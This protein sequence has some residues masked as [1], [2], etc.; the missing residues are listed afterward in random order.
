MN[1]SPRL[2]AF[3]TCLAGA[4]LYLYFATL[5]GTAAVIVLA[6]AGWLAMQAVFPRDR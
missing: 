4:G 6:L 5:H 3:A 2:L 1:R